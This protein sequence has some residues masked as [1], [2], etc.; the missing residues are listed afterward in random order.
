MSLRKFMRWCA[1]ATQAALLALVALVL[2]SAASAAGPPLV[3]QGDYNLAG[4]PVKVDGTLG[5]AIDTFGAPST[6]R[7][8]HGYADVACY[9]SWS[10][11]GL[12]ISFYNLGGLNPCSAEGGLFSTATTTGLRW[13]T[14][15]GLHIR[16]SAT[17]IGRLY[18]AAQFHSDRFYGQAWWIVTRRSYIGGGPHD[19]PGLLARVKNGRVSAFVVNFP[20]GGD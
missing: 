20:A 2:A 5:G 17:R 15:K 11:L 9:A 14:A 10:G 4:F 1:M 8:G 7:R 6:L 18:P 3:I 19:Y 12:R 16:D 13:R